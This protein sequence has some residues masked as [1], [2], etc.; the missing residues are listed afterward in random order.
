MYIRLR[1]VLAIA[2]YVTSLCLV[3]LADTSQ[4]RVCFMQQVDC[5][6]VMYLPIMLYACSVSNS[7]KYA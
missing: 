4:V 2:F 1:Y 6:S 5:V 7:Y 3:L